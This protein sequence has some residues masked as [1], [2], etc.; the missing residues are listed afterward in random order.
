MALTR[1][2]H[3]TLRDGSV[4]PLTLLDFEK[5]EAF[6]RDNR[7]SGG[8][9]ELEF[10]PSDETLTEL[11]LRHVITA[12]LGAGETLIGEYRFPR[13]SGSRIRNVFHT[14]S[15][16]VPS[17]A[18]LRANV[19]RLDWTDRFGSTVF[20]NFQTTLLNTIDYNGGSAVQTSSVPGFQ[21]RTGH[22]STT[23]GFAIN[24]RGNRRRLALASLGTNFVRDSHFQLIQVA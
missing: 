21:Q 19:Y 18:D 8:F 5:I 10:D 6:R 1:D 4:Q 24:T 3:A 2:Y 15:I 7:G 20:D 23:L 22:N 14:T 9:I 16:D 11:N 13:N 12:A 17:D